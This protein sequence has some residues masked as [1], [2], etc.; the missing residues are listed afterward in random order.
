MIW[1]DIELGGGERI[2]IVPPM[3]EWFKL[4]AITLVI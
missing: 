1:H 3:V 2:Y 4:I